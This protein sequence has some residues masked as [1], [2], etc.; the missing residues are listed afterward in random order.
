[1]PHSTRR[2]R[3]RGG[4]TGRGSVHADRTTR[5]PGQPGVWLRCFLD[6]RQEPDPQPPGPSPAFGP[7]PRPPQRAPG[8]AGASCA[9]TSASRRTRSASHQALLLRTPTPP[10]EQPDTGERDGRSRAAVST[11]VK[12]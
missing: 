1:M 9:L 3:W 2:G 10:L 4:R 5:E 11:P 12:P 6:L 8:T 7:L